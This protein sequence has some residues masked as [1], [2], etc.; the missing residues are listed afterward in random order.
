MHSHASD[1]RAQLE[2]TASRSHHGVI[3]RS[4]ATAS[5][6]TRAQIDRRVRQGQW[7]SGPAR[8]TLLLVSHSKDPLALL[9]AATRGHRAVA[10]GQSALALWNLANHPIRP[11]IASERDI[12]SKSV[13]SHSVTDLQNLPLVRRQGLATASLELGLASVAQSLN[14]SALNEIVD[15][16]LRRQ[17][18]TWDRVER[19]FHR[20]TR[21]GRPGSTM[22]RLLIEDRS[23]DSAI[24]LSQWSRDFAFKLVGSGLPRP[25]ME[26]RIKDESGSLLAQVDL[27]YP[28][29]RYAIELDSIK[30]HFNTD[31]FEVDRYR[32]AD[33]SRQG[34]SV[35][36]F[37]WKQFTHK[38]DWVTSVVARQLGIPR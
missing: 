37:T 9:S 18:S 12:G 17:L 24:P 20:Y 4:D 14:Q 33:L 5:G 26:W 13:T 1:V 19:T 22:I 16:T 21:R 32:D 30:H 34:W 8:G 29:H 10:W 6:M 38:W 31:A 23:V 27:A 28:E 7:I 25:R 2:R 11:V 36:R 3:L 35:G 15:E